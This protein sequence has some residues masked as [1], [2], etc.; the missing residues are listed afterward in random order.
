MLGGLLGSKFTNKCKHSVKC[1]KTRLV[2]ITRKKQAMVGFLKK[3]VAELIAKGFDSKAFE[4]MDALI[5]EINHARCYDMIE[6]YCDCLLNQLPS[7]HKQR[8]CPENATE[9]VSTLIF[10]AARFSD[11]P[12]LCDLRRA[13]LDRFGSDSDSFVNSEFVENMQRKSFSMDKKLQLMHDIT[14][15][16]SVSWD[17]RIFKQKLSSSAPASDESRKGVPVRNGNNEPPGKTI[18][19]GNGAVNNVGNKILPKERYEPTPKTVIQKQEIQPGLKGIQKQEIQPG[20]KGIQKQEI[21]PGLKGIQVISS[22]N[23]GRSHDPSFKRRMAFADEP[24]NIEPQSRPA[25]PPYSNLNTKIAGSDKHKD[26]QIGDAIS[27]KQQPPSVQQVGL[28]KSQDNNP[29][30][31]VPPYTKTKV[32]NT[33]DHTVDHA[34]DGS[35]FKKFSRDEDESDP[36][37]HERQ[38][39]RQ[40]NYS[41]D[42]VLNKVPPPYIKP[43]VNLVNAADQEFSITGNGG[44]HAGDIK[45]KKFIEKQRPMSVRSKRPKQL[46]LDEIDSSNDDRKLLSQTPDLQKRRSDKESAATFYDAGMVKE[47]HPNG[48]LA[49]K[50]ADAIDYQR[51]PTRTPTEQMQVGKHRVTAYDDDH[52]DGGKTTGSKLEMAGVIDVAIDYQRKPT[53]TPTERMQVG[54]HRAAAYDDDHYDGGKTMGSKIEMPGVIGDAIDY[55]KLMSRPPRNQVRQGHGSSTAMRDGN[56]YGVGKTS[57][58]RAPVADEEDDAIDYGKLL[59]Q[60]P[61]GQRRG[62]R[63]TGNHDRDEEERFMD[64]LLIHYSKK[65]LLDNA[66]TGPER[67]ASDHAANE[68]EAYIRRGK[69]AKPL[70]HERVVSLPPQPISPTE[71]RA[72][73]R[74]TSLQPNLF[75]PTAG[76]AHPRIPEYE[77]VAAQMA[78]LRIKQ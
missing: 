54:K 37:G 74:A 52:Y 8:E 39:V 5:V 38:P 16:F 59:H 51:K 13:F 32:A 67:P 23:G 34:E 78:A 60:N 55:G 71:P 50:V 68:S 61:S 27:H 44:S 64:R 11:L 20:F 14:Q 18:S 22:V 15:E 35:S 66:S 24:E 4:R 75:G 6:K 9:A 56:Y 7:M 1:V 43:S 12:E 2:V 26:K 63:R 41:H 76:R 69:A 47:A 30:Y 36:S 77:D 3:D 17:V 70:L 10:A 40:L 31:I 25:V 46:I 19:G 53:R 33:I 58:P 48:L 65:G 21:Q 29:V 57:N 45:D 72:P 62:G 28:V 42:R 49:G 73:T